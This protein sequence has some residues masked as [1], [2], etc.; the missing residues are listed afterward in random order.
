M[1]VWNFYLLGKSGKVCTYW[2]DLWL[3]KYNPNEP[4][5]DKL[6]DDTIIAIKVSSNRVANRIANRV[7]LNLC[8]VIQKKRLHLKLQSY[9]IKGPSTGNNEITVNNK[10]NQLVYSISLRNLFKFSKKNMKLIWFICSKLLINI[11]E[12][13]NLSTWLWAYSAYS[14]SLFNNVR[15]KILLQNFIPRYF[16]QTK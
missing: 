10:I 14:V 13:C 1:R 12:S 8:K 4:F 16:W 5:T 11:L 15:T 3:E 6:F 2:K 7:Y 9:L